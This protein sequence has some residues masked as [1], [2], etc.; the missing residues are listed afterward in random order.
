[1]KSSNPA[2]SG[3][4]FTGLSFSANR[5]DAMT[6]QGTVYK[7]FLL[8]LLV[9]LSA[10]W[11]WNKFYLAGGNAASV[12]TWMMIGVFGGF[13]V[14][15]VTVFKKQ[16]ASITAPL[17]AVLE[18]LFIGGL[19][20]TLE[21][22]YPGIVIQSAGLTFGTLFAMLLAYQAGLK[23][24]ENFKMGVFAATGGIAIFYLAMM[25]LSFFGIQPSFMYGNSLL[26]IGI[27]LFVVVIAALNFIIDFDIIEQGA[28][29]SM[30]KYMEWYGAFALMVTLI[31]LYIEFL[32]LLSKIRSR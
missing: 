4:T 28:R 17:Y 15:M 29:S 8:L 27:S 2:L 26:S 23:A 18:G 9:M 16:W 32:R 24:T 1:M 22:S 12:S 20:A 5:A 14:A 6:I 11:T 31:W 10:G 21:A 19:S 30:P 3:E 25:V 7:T 13:I